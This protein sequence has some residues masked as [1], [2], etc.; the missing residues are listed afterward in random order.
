MRQHGL[1]RGRRDD[2]AGHVGRVD[3]LLNSRFC[4]GRFRSRQQ[5]AR[6]LAAKH[7]AAGP[8]ENGQERNVRLGSPHSIPRNPDA[9]R[10]AE[11]RGAEVLFE[12]LGGERE[13]L[14]RD[15][16][17]RLFVRVVKGVHD[18]LS[19]NR[20]GFLFGVVEIDSS[21]KSARRHLARLRVHGG[22]P[23]NYHLRR[24]LEDGLLL[25]VIPH[26]GELFG[27]IGKRRFAAPCGQEE[28]RQHQA[29]TKRHVHRIVLDHV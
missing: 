2:A 5:I 17:G 26:P 8:C 22:G 29:A 21:A 25:L 1:V 10:G 4:L 9:I 3:R 19:V 11:L 20:D 7:A 15:L 16:A 27:E 13:A 23:D 28:H 6:L 18:Q 14:I 24:L 12:L